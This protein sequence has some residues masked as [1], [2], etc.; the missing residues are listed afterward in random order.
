[1]DFD[2]EFADLDFITLVDTAEHVLPTAET[3]PEV[4]TNRECDTTDKILFVYCLL[5]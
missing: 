1:M 2:L 4:C 3:L 5:D